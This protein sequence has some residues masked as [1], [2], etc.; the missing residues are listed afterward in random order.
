[1]TLREFGTDGSCVG[2]ASK[3]STFQPPESVDGGTS[4]FVLPIRLQIKV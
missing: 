3:V 4:G 1:M 2:L